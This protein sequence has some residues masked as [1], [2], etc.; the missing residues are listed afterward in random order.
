MPASTKIHIDDVRIQE[1][2]ARAPARAARISA[3]AKAAEVAF[4]A[5]Q[6]IHRILFGADDRLLVIGPCSIHDPDA[7]MEYALKLKAEAERLKD[8]L[9]IVMRVYFEK[10]HH[11]GLE[12]ADQRSRVGQ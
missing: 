2:K 9:L 7:A 4:E 12:G 1:I 5:R 10:P 8:D 11:G 6:S 3:T